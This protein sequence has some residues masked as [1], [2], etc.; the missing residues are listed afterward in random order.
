[1]KVKSIISLL[2]CSAICVIEFVPTSCSIC[3][4]YRWGYL[5][6][7]FESYNVNLTHKTSSG[8]EYD[9]SGQ[10]ISPDLIDRLTMEVENC[11]P[12]SI[13]RQSFSVKIVNDYVLSCDKTEQLL[14]TNAPNSGCYAKGEKPTEQCPCRWR[15][16][17]KCPNILVTTPSFLLYKDVLIRF[18]L[19][20]KDPWA[21]THLSVCATPTNERTK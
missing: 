13:D 6:A 19:N 20:N 10:N 18:I 9:P 2:G 4:P 5:G 1:M 8:I 21:D 11:I 12:I 14:N 16:G 7:P 15:S 3:D 17:I